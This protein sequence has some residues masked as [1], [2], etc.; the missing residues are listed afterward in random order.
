MIASI[1]SGNDTRYQ[2]IAT[3]AQLVESR[4]VSGEIGVQV[5]MVAPSL[6]NR[7]SNTGYKIIQDKV[8]G[9]FIIQRYN[10]SQI[11]WTF[12]TS[13]NTMKEAEQW[14]LDGVKRK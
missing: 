4:I 3:I 6:G 1:E 9:D 11:G 2:T 8:K 10:G 14:I 13:K 5:L 7:M 12:V